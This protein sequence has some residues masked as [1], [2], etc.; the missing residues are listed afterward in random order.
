MAKDKEYLI[1]LIFNKLKNNNNSSKLNLEKKEFTEY[2][3]SLI[4]NK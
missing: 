2:I 1:E 4:N 3:N